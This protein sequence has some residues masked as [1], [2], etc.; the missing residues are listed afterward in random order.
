MYLVMVCPSIIPLAIITLSGVLWPHPGLVYFF[1]PT[2]VHYATFFVFYD[3][4]VEPF[5]TSLSFLALAL[6]NRGLTLMLLGQVII[7]IITLS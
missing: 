1:S 6:S 7:L 5:L 4:F 2:Q 3:T